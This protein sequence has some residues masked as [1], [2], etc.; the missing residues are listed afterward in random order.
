MTKLYKSHEPLPI[1]KAPDDCLET[2]LPLPYRRGNYRFKFKKIG[3]PTGANT[4]MVIAYTRL[5]RVADSRGYHHFRA[6]PVE[7]Y[8]RRIKMYY[9][10]KAEPCQ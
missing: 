10:N 3:E 1:V 2:H 7:P 9:Y 5:V 8:K 4:I 6:I